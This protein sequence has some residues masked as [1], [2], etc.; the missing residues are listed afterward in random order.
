MEIIFR[1]TLVTLIAFKE[2]CAVCMHV[3]DKRKHALAEKLINDRQ[4][5]IEF[6]KTA[7]GAMINSVERTTSSNPNI[8]FIELIR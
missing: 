5:N 8:V 7:R 4:C 3:K 1:S 6:K 2:I